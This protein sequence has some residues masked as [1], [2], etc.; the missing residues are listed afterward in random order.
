VEFTPRI[1]VKE[2]MPFEAL[3]QLEIRVPLAQDAEAGSPR[4]APGARRSAWVELPVVTSS[5]RAVPDT[6]SNG[7][8]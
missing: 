2:G 7:W 8:W 5:T 3:E 1:I 4:R 6:F